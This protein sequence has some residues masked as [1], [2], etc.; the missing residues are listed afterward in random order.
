[1]DGGAEKLLCESLRDLG[2]EYR[3]ETGRLLNNRAENS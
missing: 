3:Q 1:M 2:I